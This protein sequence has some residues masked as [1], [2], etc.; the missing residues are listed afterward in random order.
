[1][2]VKN[3]YLWYMGWLYTSS[4]YTPAIVGTTTVYSRLPHSV[5]NIY[6]NIHVLFVQIEPYE[7]RA[8]Y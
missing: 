6:N 4:V 1:M 3:I 7:I 8:S 5:E 2:S